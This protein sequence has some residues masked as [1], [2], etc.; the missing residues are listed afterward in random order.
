MY[1]DN[2]PY[3][4][5]LEEIRTD[6]SDFKLHAALGLTNDS[7]SLEAGKRL[8]IFGLQGE[9]IRKILNITNIDLLCDLRNTINDKWKD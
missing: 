2:I 3:K 9:I 4:F 6:K 5:T 8:M 1:K 7:V